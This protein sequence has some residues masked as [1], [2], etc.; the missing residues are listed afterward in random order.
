MIIDIH[1]HIA[2]REVEAENP[3]LI[4]YILSQY[5]IKR[6]KLDDFCD[7]KELTYLGKLLLYQ[8]ANKP[9]NGIDKAVIL[10]LDSN[11]LGRCPNEEILKA[12]EN[13]P[14]YFIG[15]V[16]V[17]PNRDNA[18]KL[19]D[20]T[21]KKLLKIQGEQYKPVL[22]LV[23]SGQ[24][25]DPGNVNEKYWQ[26][27]DE[28]STLLIAHTGVSIAS[29]VEQDE[30][31]DPILWAPVVEKYHNLAVL[32]SHNGTQNNLGLYPEHFDHALEMMLRFPNYFGD[33]SGLLYTELETGRDFRL[34][35]KKGFETLAENLDIP[36]HYDSSIK[37]KNKVAGGTDFP[38]VI[39]INESRREQQES[40]N[41]F[42]CF[43]NS[44]GLI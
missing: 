21:I 10:A 29:P 42:D 5:S 41:G 28:Y 8:L 43:E 39:N 12:V 22:K 36:T 17:N 13:H 16:S 7:D 32:G 1:T 40:L 3:Q 31:A 33:M 35:S 44:E 26:V 15:S 14:E 11:T 2:S 20:K 4:D 9:E 25:F 23:P 24:A 18:P 37:L 38:I 30:L 27:C 6:Q 19:L 34:I